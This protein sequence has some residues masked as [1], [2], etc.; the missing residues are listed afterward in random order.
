MTGRL[1]SL[2]AKYT[3]ILRE[4]EQMPDIRLDRFCRKHGI[5]LW[6]YY[7]WKKRLAANP[8]TQ[9]V[10]TE[11]FVPVVMNRLEQENGSWAE[12]RYPNGILLRCT[13][14]D[15]PE[16]LAQLAGALRG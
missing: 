15:S 9:V 7:H 2:E 16:A 14:N 3:R 1:I 13:G 12:V 4:R 11:P 8:S 5:S 10:R 6:T